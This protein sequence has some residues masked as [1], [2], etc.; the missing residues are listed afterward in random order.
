MGFVGGILGV[1]LSLLVDILIN[2]RLVEFMKMPEDTWMMVTPVWLLLA[3]VAASVL[4]AVLA[5]A[6][7]ARWAS[8]IKPLEAIAG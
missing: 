6:F 8:K 5:G 3:A 4:V 2:K 7:P 1:G